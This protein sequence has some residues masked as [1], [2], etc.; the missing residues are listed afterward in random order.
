MAAFCS[1]RRTSPTA[2]MARATRSIAAAVMSL[3]MGSP[4]AVADGKTA[5]GADSDAIGRIG[6]TRVLESDIVAADRVEFERLRRGFDVQQ[7]QLQVKYEEAR[8]ALLQK[9]LDLL[10]DRKALEVE[11]QARHV[12]PEAVLADMH[13]DEPTEAQAHA[14]Y[15]GNKERI[16]APYPQVAPKILDYLAGQARDSANRAFYDELRNK[17]GIAASLAP[18]R[19]SV[20]ALGP[21]R[22]QSNAAVTIIEFADFQCPF[23]RQAESSLRSVLANRLVFRNLPLEEIHPNARIAAQAGV[24]A[25]RQGKFWEMHDAMYGDQGS[26]NPDALKS[27]AK[28]LGLDTG[29]FSTCL[30]DGSANASLEAD[31]K[32]ALELGLDGT[33]SMFINGRP[34]EGDVPEEKLERIIAEELLRATRQPG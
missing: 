20:A 10:L 26:L 32:A 28:R 19:R 14:F 5:P 27:T 16:N 6:S 25:D 13:V 11:A 4:L 12:T 23:C 3:A 31:T 18:Y 7:H 22:G 34:L 21:A 1:N 8:H 30:T 2:R 29:R 33:P 15:D 17:H 24:C 9:Q